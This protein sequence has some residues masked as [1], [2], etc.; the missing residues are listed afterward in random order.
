MFQ[1]GVKGHHLELNRAG[2]LVMMLET[3][4]SII[5]RVQVVHCYGSKR[6]YC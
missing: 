5:K 2:S 3:N 4:E 6:F 1:C